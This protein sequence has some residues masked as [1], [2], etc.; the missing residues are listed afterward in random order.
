MIKV[1]KEGKQ[2]MNDVISNLMRIGDTN[3]LDW[4]KKVR[5]SVELIEEKPKNKK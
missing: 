2:L 3:S 4:I 1:D 5:D